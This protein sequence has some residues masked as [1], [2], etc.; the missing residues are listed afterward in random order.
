MSTT[1]GNT[2]VGAVPSFL[3]IEEPLNKFRIKNGV[4][5]QAIKIDTIDQ[6]TN[7][8]NIYIEWRNVPEVDASVPDYEPLHQSSNWF[9]P[10]D[11]KTT[12]IS[13]TAP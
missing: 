9:P 6:S 11:D 10:F 3:T 1:T 2:I 12:I 8:Y 7:A 13:E 5:Q 4:L